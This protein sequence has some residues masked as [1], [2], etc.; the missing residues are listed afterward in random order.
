M[1]AVTSADVL[2]ALRVRFAPPQWYLMTEVA[3][4][5]GYSGKTRETYADAVAI[6]AYQ[7]GKFAAEIHVVEIKVSRAD[8]KGELGDAG[9]LNEVA[10]HCDRVWLAVPAP[11][12]MIVRDGELP[13]TW[14]LLEV[15]GTEA[16]A[17][18]MA[19]LLHKAHERP[20]LPRSFIAAM[21]RRASEE[22]AE[23]EALKGALLRAPMRQ[24]AHGDYW[25]GDLVL[26]CGHVIRSQD[27]QRGIPKSARCL[28]CADGLPPEIDIVRKA[29][30]YMSASELRSLVEDASRRATDIEVG[31]LH[32]NDVG[33]Q[34]IAPVPA[35]VERERAALE[36]ALAE[37][38][39]REAP[40]AY[41]AALATRLVAMATQ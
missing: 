2:A 1:G 31:K 9:K 27:R 15:N 26:Q 19:P 25:H 24:V 13:P 39:D 7:G 22:R 28:P 20:A 17:K 37:A 30:R 5:T 32:W 4:G 41:V 33:G 36:K 21:V 16:H 29:M 3:N 6:N 18:R 14:G 8:F 38:V 34:G 40:D 11:A 10:Q 23:K 12:I 35:Y